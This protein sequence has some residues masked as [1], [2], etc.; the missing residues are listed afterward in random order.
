MKRFSHWQ[1]MARGPIGVLLGVVVASF[2]LVGA[3][4]AQS[5]GGGDDPIIG[6]WILNVERSVYTP[7]PRPP[8]DLNSR[9]QYAN[10]EGGWMRFTTT[11]RNAAGNPTFQIGVFKLDGERHPVHNIGTLGRSMTTGQA[12]NL[13]RSYRVI[14][15]RTTESTTYNDGVAGIPV[16]RSVAPDGN[17]FIERVNGTTAQGVEISNAAVWERVR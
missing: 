10:L 4:G 2:V 1:S 15:P 11:S 9:R 5:A 13:T 6:A 12:S 16:V 8:A 7:G 17:S 3:A 14:N